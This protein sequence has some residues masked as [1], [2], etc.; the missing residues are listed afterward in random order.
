[1]SYR[2]R[3]VDGSEEDIADELRLLHELSFFDDTQFPDTSYGNWWIAYDD[4]GSTVA[5]SGLVPSTYR[6]G[7]GYLK[8][9]GVVPDHRGNGLHRKMTRVRE[10]KARRM[11]WNLLVTD[12]TDNVPS[13]NNLIECGFR[14]FD[15]EVKWAFANSLYW[16]K[17]L[18]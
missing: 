6:Y 11:G 14:L 15:P 17:E 7:S 10:M 18:L 9:V 8:R 2:I 16:K 12:T 1:M 3:E 13:A 5:F 4:D